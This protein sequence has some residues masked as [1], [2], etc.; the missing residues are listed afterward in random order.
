MIEYVLQYGADLNEWEHV[1][2]AEFL[3][4]FVCLSVEC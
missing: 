3:L 2:L 1:I 4:L